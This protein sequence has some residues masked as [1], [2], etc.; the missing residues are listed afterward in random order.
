MSQVKHGLI[1]RSLL[2]LLALVMLAFTLP[3]YSDTSNNPALANLSDET[4][5]LGSVAGAF[6]APQLALALSALHGAS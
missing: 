6:L 3:A 4:A 2:G 1:A 5:S